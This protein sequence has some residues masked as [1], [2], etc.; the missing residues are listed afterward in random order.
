MPTNFA[1]SAV[2]SLVDSSGNSITL[3]NLIG[4]LTDLLSTPMNVP[5]SAQLVSVD[6]NNVIFVYWT[7]Q[8]ATPDTAPATLDSTSTDDNLIPQV[9]SDL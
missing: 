7:T 2:I 9:F 4:Q 5:E 6:E 8:Y 3:Q 1:Q